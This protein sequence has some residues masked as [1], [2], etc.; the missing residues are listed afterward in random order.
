[1]GPIINTSY[2]PFIYSS[3]HISFFSFFLDQY[4]FHHF[5]LLPV[6]PYI[7]F[8]FSLTIFLLNYTTFFLIFVCFFFVFFSSQTQI[9][10]SHA[11]LLISSSSSICFIY[12][13]HNDIIT[14]SSNI[15]EIHYY[16]YYS[17]NEMK[18]E[19]IISVTRPESLYQM[20]I[21][22]YTTH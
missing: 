16:S 11:F 8:F 9:K 7:P 4:P 19:F 6:F 15:N 3:L 17:R 14:I 18:D 10:F 21:N 1:M 2:H 13:P 12:H 22:K 20:H 5:S